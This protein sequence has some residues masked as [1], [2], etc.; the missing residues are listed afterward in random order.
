MHPRVW[1][2]V[3]TRIQINQQS[4]VPPANDGFGFKL[5]T[6]LFICDFVVHPPISGGDELESQQKKGKKWET[7]KKRKTKDEK[8]EK[9]RKREGK[10]KGKKKEKKGKR[11]TKKRK[12]SKKKEKEKKKEK[13]KVKKRKKKKRKTNEETR[14]KESKKNKKKGVSFLPVGDARITNGTKKRH[15]GQYE[16]CTRDKK[17]F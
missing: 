5:S 1:D 17:T 10:N 3:D 13:K 4:P 15:A 16:K 6:S 8:K 2:L 14:K 11:I 7:N 9:K 12:T